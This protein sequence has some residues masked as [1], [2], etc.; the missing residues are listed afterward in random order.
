MS[1]RKAASKRVILPDPL[2]GSQSLAKFMNVV[3][4]SGKKACAEKIVYGALEKLIERVHSKTSGDSAKGT[5]VP[6]KKSGKI[7]AND[8]I[9][10]LELFSKVLDNIRPTVEVRSRRVGGATYQ[11]PVEVKTDR[12]IALAMRWLVTYA[13][14]R[15]EK[16]M[17]LRLAAE[18]LDAM[19]GRGGAVKKREDIHKMAKAN[20]AFA[21]YRW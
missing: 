12:G 2:F 17:A 15:G 3:M 21:H 1:R 6:K 13:S 8:K 11:I 9:L 4:Q 18:M 20:Q 16:T 14:S 5:K 7:D 19:D 10:A